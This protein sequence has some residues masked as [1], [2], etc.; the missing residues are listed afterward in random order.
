ML[1]LDTTACKEAEEFA[2]A[3]FD[4][5]DF[6]FDRFDIAKDGTQTRTK[7]KIAKIGSNVANAMDEDDG[8][9]EKDSLVTDDEVKGDVFKGGHGDEAKSDQGLGV[10][11][12]GQELSKLV[13]AIESCFS[14]LD[15]LENPMVTMK[16]VLLQHMVEQGKFPFQRS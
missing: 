1:D 9:D 16:V 5:D 3:L 13:T 10:K 2:R 11:N 14:H 6:D 12:H 15:S 7:A 4:P 8:V